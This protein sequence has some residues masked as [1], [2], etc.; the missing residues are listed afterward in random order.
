MGSVGGRVVGVGVS[1]ME[2]GMGQEVWGT[3]GFN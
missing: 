2:V 1:A 3:E